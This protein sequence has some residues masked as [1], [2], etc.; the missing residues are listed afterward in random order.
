[1]HHCSIIVKSKCGAPTFDIDTVAS[2]SAESYTPAE[3]WSVSYMEYSQSEPLVD[4]PPKDLVLK[5][6]DLTLNPGHYKGGMLYDLSVWY[7]GN[8]RSKYHSMLAPARVLLDWMAP[9]ISDIAAYNEYVAEGGAYQLRTL[10]WNTQ[11]AK[12]ATADY[13]S[14]DAGLDLKPVGPT[15]AFLN[16]TI[17]WR[18]ND[19]GLRFYSAE[20]PHVNKPLPYG[21][22]QYSA[23]PSADRFTIT[24]G[25]GKPSSGLW[26][27]GNGGKSFGVRGQGNKL[28]GSDKKEVALS[29]QAY[30]FR[31]PVQPADTDKCTPSYIALSVV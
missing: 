8:T 27:P 10:F 23:V 16:A 28:I 26:I 29:D 21:G 1:M 6:E 25:Y 17:P 24:S 7:Q 11:Y 12:N 5:P 9:Y 31:W 14:A 22:P 15:D 3:L 20:K 18:Y 30:S 4:T 19:A 13:Y 2:V